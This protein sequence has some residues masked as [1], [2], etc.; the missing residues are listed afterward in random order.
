[1]VEDDCVFVSRSQKVWAVCELWFHLRLWHHYQA[2][3]D[4]TT[5]DS[6]TGVKKRIRFR[7]FI[8]MA[9]ELN[10]GV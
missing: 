5:V 7:M 1:M 3:V 2:A 10:D 4:S 9:D 8:F 6:E